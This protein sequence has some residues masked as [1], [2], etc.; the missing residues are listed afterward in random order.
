MLRRKTG[1][2]TSVEVF[3]LN[4]KSG[5]RESFGLSDPAFP[6]P[7]PPQ[8]GANAYDDFFYNQKEKYGVNMKFGFKLFPKTS[9]FVLES[10]VGLGLALRKNRHTDRENIQDKL[11]YNS[12]PFDR[13]EGNKWIFNFPFNIKLGHR[14]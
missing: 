1:L 13:A 9:G 6:Y 8:Q 3:Y 7:D 10:Y 14:F 11:L 12:F 5:V 2:Y 4:N